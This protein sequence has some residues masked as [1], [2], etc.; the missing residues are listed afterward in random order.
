M[1]RGKYRSLVRSV[2]RDIMRS[3]IDNADIR[4]YRTTLPKPNLYYL[5]D[6]KWK[7]DLNR[8]PEA[9]GFDVSLRVKRSKGAKFVIYASVCEDELGNSHIEVEIIHD[10]NEKTH[11]SELYY[12]L[13]GSIRHEIEHISEEG[14]LAGLGPTQDVVVPYITNKSKIV[15]T[16]NLRS[17][18]FG[19][20]YGNIEGWGNEEQRRLHSAIEGGM[21]DYL[22]CY[23]E[24]GPLTQ[25]FY[26][27]AKKRRIP[28]DEVIND[29]LERFYAGGLLTESEID[30]AFNHLVAWT[31]LTLPSAII[32]S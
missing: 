19:D 6:D 23:E 3:I 11:L 20:L 22:T 9:V 14:Q 4:R 32:V 26:Y 15:H 31:R 28:T 13:A 25:G 12:E 21:L 29:Y 1:A 16:I 24:V 18:I 5:W 10:P 30:E 2:T 8:C 17:K 7:T 27:E